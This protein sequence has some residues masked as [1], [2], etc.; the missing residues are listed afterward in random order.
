MSDELLSPE[1]RAQIE[2][3]L[4]RTLDPDEAASVESFTAFDDSDIAELRLIR[5]ELNSVYAIVFMKYKLKGHMPLQH[6]I[7]FSEAVLAGNTPQ[8]LWD[9]GH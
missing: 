2:A 6:A 7:Y 3:T 9:P 4:G 8:A 5:R 1:I